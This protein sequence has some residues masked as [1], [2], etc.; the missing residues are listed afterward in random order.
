MAIFRD[1][2]NTANLVDLGFTG[3]EFT[4]GQNSDEGVKCQLDK[5]L[6]TQG[7]QDLFPCQTV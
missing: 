6:S 7:W 4:W 2:V 1:A 5:G 3:N